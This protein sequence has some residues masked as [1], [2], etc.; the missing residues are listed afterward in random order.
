[1]A[2][3]RTRTPLYEPARTLLYL[4]QLNRRRAPLP[5]AENTTTLKRLLLAV[6]L[7]PLCFHVRDGRPSLPE[8]YA[9]PQSTIGSYWH[10]MIE[11][12]HTEALDCFLGAAPGDIAHMLALPEVVELRPRDFVVEWGA[13][14]TAD[15]HYRIEYR[16]TLG[17]SLASFATGDRLSLTST[18]W[19]IAHPLL[20]ADARP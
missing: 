10:R 11:R 14:G 17:D 20:L 4:P 2:R 3:N 5:A 13:G 9:T 16:I 18:G 19:K 8:A 7:A 15:V 1:M 6:L 12:R